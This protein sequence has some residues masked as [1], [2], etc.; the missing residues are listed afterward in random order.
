M[1]VDDEIAYIAE[2][3]KLMDVQNFRMTGWKVHQKIYQFDIKD[4][5]VDAWRR[6]IDSQR[7]RV[8]YRVYTEDQ[9]AQLRELAGATYEQRLELIR[10]WDRAEREARND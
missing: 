9:V 6:I 4:S 3:T 5:L 2:S 8:P 1:V 10:S 7:F